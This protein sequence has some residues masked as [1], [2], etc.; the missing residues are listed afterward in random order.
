MALAGAELLLYPTAIGWDRSTGQ[1]PAYT[2]V[3]PWLARAMR[4]NS[5]LDVLVA[6]GYYDLATPFFGAELMFNQPGFDPER[7]HFRYYEAGHMMYI[8][9]PSLEAVV[10]DVRE[11]IRGELEG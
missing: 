11:L 3:G 4:Q 7:V 5:D 2:N 8:H 9:E 1:G 6:Q 10:E